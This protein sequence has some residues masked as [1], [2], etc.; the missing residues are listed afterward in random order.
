MGQ[1]AEQQQLN[2]SV[3]SCQPPAGANAMA[4]VAIADNVVIDVFIVHFLLG[5]LLT[6]PTANGQRALAKNGPRRTV[7]FMTCTSGMSV[8]C[9]FE[10]VRVY[11]C[12]NVAED[13]LKLQFTTS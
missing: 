8:M 12:V 5:T 2:P 10:C 7:N 6:R 3:A 11:E 1:A 9:H 13:A 4:N